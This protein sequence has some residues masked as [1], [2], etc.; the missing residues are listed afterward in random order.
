MTWSIIEFIK[1]WILPVIDILAVSYIIYKTY[2]ILYG[3]RAILVLNGIIV[4]GVI[5][6]ISKFLNLTTLHLILNLFITYGIIMFII[7]FQP[8]IRQALMRVGENKF[9]PLYSRTNLIVI[10]EIVEAVS[11]MSKKKIGALIVLKRKAGLKN[12]ENTG[13]KIDA[14]LSKELLLT[15]FAK[16]TPLHDGAIIIEGNRITY[17]SCF[18]PLSEKRISKEFGTRH[19]AALGLS[20]ESDAIILI[21]S[22]ESG[23][24]SIALEGKLYTDKNEIELKNELTRLLS[25]E[26]D[27]YQKNS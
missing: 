7:V 18:L 19:R 13:I 11:F 6:L 27:R 9:I 20:E 14:I 12:V 22:E 3:T 8:E 2:M 1:T 24:I 16:N 25:E 23:K 21:V 5:Y 17:S 26:N 4:I 15:I 10:P